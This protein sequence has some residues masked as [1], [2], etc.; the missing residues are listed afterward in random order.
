VRLVDDLSDEDRLPVFDLQLHPFEA[1]GVAV[2]E[3]ASHHYA[4]DHHC[5]P[6]HDLSI[7]VALSYTLIRRS[8][9]HV[10]GG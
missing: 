9:K 2:T 1:R 7:L 8:Y 5:T 10:G 4:V 3:L 6:M